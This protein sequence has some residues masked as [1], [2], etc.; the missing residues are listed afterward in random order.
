[1]SV[2]RVRCVLVSVDRICTL[3]GV[4]Q[5]QGRVAREAG[6]RGRA[7]LFVEEAPDDP[8][9]RRYL[10]IADAN[11]REDFARRAMCGLPVALDVV[12]AAHN[13]DDY[14][15][16]EDDDDE[17]EEEEQ[18]VDDDDLRPVSPLS[19]L[20]LTT[21][22][23]ACTPVYFA[24]DQLTPTQSQEQVQHVEQQP[25]RAAAAPRHRRAPAVAQWRLQDRSLP[26]HGAP[27][28]F[29]KQQ[30]LARIKQRLAQRGPGSS[31]G[32]DQYDATTPPTATAQLLQPR[33]PYSSI[34]PQALP[35]TK[36]KAP[37]Q[38]SLPPHPKRG[39]RMFAAA[40]ATRVAEQYEL[41]RRLRCVC[42][43]CVVAGLPVRDVQHR[44]YYLNQCPSAQAVQLHQVCN[45]SSCCTDTLSC[46]NYQLNNTAA[47][48]VKNFDACNQCWLSKPHFGDRHARH[49]CEETT[50]FLV[51]TVGRLI[52]HDAAKRAAFA[53]A[54]PDAVQQE[55]D[56]GM[57]Q[58]GYWARRIAH[59]T[60][61]NGM[62]VVV[63]CMDARA[64]V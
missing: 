23:A 44:D 47:W 35:A 12:G 42:P 31:S 11:A 20:D 48:K 37:A 54:F 30:P 49:K 10:A 61:T 46:A 51:I 53:R 29:I 55:A 17:E 40:N 8:L 41:L 57:E 18:K 25:R 15:R 34:T 9:L 58:F 19:E 24:A 56:R 3:Y 62:R 39:Q 64:G 6:E 21:P 14:E 52:L 63:W 43:R 22:R 38:P 4:L 7:L 32:G 36:R 13:D 50:K 27:Q 1:M 28:S 59:D 26:A 5:A 60:V 2:P 45:K 33:G 16:E